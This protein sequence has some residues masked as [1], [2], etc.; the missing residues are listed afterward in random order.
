MILS[1]SRVD[2]LHAHISA[3]S[4]RSARTRSVCALLL[5]LWLLTGCA[6]DAGAVAAQ[7]ESQ[8]SDKGRIE[9]GEVEFG[10]LVTRPEPPLPPT[11]QVFRFPTPTPTSSATA[12]P[13]T[14]LPKPVIPTRQLT[15]PAAITLDASP[16]P[17]RLAVLNS[18]LLNAYPATVAGERVT[19]HYDPASP[20]AI[21]PDELAVLVVQILTHHEQLLG[22]TL[23]GQFDVYTAGTLFAAPDQALRGHSFSQLR[24]FQVVV[25]ND[26]A[27]ATQRYI[28]AHG[29]THLLAWNTFGAPSSVLLSEGLAAYA[30]L[31]F[32]GDALI[33]LHDFCTAYSRAG[34]LPHVSDNLAYL[35]HI[36]NLEH[37]YAA[38][39]F[40]QF[41]IEQ[42]GVTTF[43]QL[44]PTGD[45]M[46]LYGQS[47]A[48][49][50]AEWLM[51][52][53]ARPLATPLD[54]AALV[55][56]VTKTKRA[57]LA[58]LMN[59]EGRPEQVDAY[60]RLDAQWSAVLAGRLPMDGLDG[61][62]MEHE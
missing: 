25:D 13:E 51:A 1:N 58:L 9:H 14:V 36:R 43:A 59:F 33:S 18:D 60:R 61:E 34:V 44:Y 57:Y 28:V 47:L 52:S 15:E 38:G 50:E 19:L 2:C 12:A 53:A 17:Y 11:T 31:D 5:A 22:V 39:C 32:V 49:L 10:A 30:G 20:P 21:A 41:L 55:A 24:Y 7:P 45:Y 46:G 56:A 37:Y 62:E 6:V 42:Y 35:G 16:T 48:A 54:P 3:M 26:I 27:S 29:L 40:V 4:M 8:L 23:G